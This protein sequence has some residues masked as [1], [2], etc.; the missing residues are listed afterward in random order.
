MVRARSGRGG[1]VNLNTNFVTMI[2]VE[3]QSEKVASPQDSGN[4][5]DGRDSRPYPDDRRRTTDR[6]SQRRPRVRSARPPGVAG[7]VNRW[8]GRR[9][10]ARLLDDRGADLAAVFPAFLRIGAALRPIARPY[11]ESEPVRAGCY[12]N[13]LTAARSAGAAPRP[14][15]A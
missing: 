13:W 1:G 7:V 2:P 10:I 8:P 3:Q 9:C 14:L 5:P 6:T 15:G 12:S 4:G 11:P